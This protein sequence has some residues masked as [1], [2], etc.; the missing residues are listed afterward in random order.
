MFFKRITAEGLSHHSY[1]DDGFFQ[2]KVNFHDKK[3]L[4]HCVILHIKRKY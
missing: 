2:Q 4:A 1:L 3:Y